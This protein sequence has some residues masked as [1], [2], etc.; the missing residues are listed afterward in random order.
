MARFVIVI[1]E[2]GERSQ[3]RTTQFIA[4]EIKKAMDNLFKHRYEIEVKGDAVY[5]DEREVSSI[6]Y[7]CFDCCRVLD[8]SGFLAVNAAGR[9]SCSRCGS[10][11][12]DLN[13]VQRDVYDQAIRKEETNGKET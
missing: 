2:V 11:E 4:R 8:I 3:E 5:L 1:A 6:R 9:K 10:T 12:N 13:V 7:A